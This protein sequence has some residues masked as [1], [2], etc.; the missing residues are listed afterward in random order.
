VG[1]RSAGHAAHMMYM[2]T[3]CKISVVKREGKLLLSR[4]RRTWEDNVVMDHR[5]MW[6]EVADWIRPA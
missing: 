2:T 6:F 5:E 4:P 3:A 1:I